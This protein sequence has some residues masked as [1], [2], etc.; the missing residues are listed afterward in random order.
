MTENLSAAL[1]ELSIETG[2]ATKKVSILAGQLEKAF[3]SLVMAREEE[4]VMV[5]RV[6]YTI[7]RL[8]IS[9]V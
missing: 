3:L 1:A 9:K 5:L 7:Y 4:T 2:K 8:M 6:G